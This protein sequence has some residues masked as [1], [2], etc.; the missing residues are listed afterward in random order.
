MVHEYFQLTSY[1][2][3]LTRRVFLPLLLMPL[4]QS[5]VAAEIALDNDK[6]GAI[7]V[8]GEIQAGDE[9][10]L[11]QLARGKKQVF[12]H[13]DSTGGDVD[14][15]IAIGKIV[16]E[17]DGFVTVTGRCYSACVL[18]FAGGVTRFGS[19]NILAERSEVTGV[20]VHRMYFATLHG[21]L[22]QDQ[23]KLQYQNELSRIRKYLKEMDVAPEFLSFMQS[24]EPEDVH[25]MTGD[26][27]QQYGLGGDVVY[28]ERKTAD[29]ASWLGITSAEY[30]QRRLR[31]ADA[32][33]G[34]SQECQ[35]VDATPSAKDR[36]T[37]ARYHIPLSQVM[38][39]DCS[40]A[41]QYGT[42]VEE[43]QQRSA[44]VSERCEEFTDTTQNN[45]CEDHFMATG[46]VVRKEEM[47]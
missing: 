3:G 17:H 1:M 16:R 28:D 5:I 20:G 32:A 24:I 30:R 35:T 4:N 42:S 21:G 26:E 47:K 38:K 9:L 6:T 11:A 7:T 15:A 18:I 36:A 33:S 40:L 29:Q 27:L 41:I 10:V 34:K 19:S 45:Y 22:T 12:V 13:L 44:V 31:S 37:A 46:Q 14:T 23:V 2:N 39:V 25:L 8:T 43:Y